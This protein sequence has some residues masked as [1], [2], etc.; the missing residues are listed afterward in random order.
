MAL[1]PEQ[2]IKNKVVT[3][4]IPLGGYMRMAKG[5]AD[6]L[7]LEI[8]TGWPY[9]PV[10]KNSKI[11]GLRTRANAAGK[12]AF[13]EMNN[14]DVFTIRYVGTFKRVYGYLREVSANFDDDVTAMWTERKGSRVSKYDS[15]VPET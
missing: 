9:V 7:S 10:G 8:Q 15:I 12:A 14:G 1:T 3:V 2:Q 5:L 11:G 13:L 6:F 4:E